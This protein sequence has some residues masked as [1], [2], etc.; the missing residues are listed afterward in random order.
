MKFQRAGLFL[1]LASTAIAVQGA[2]LDFNLAS[3]AVAVDY[4]AS[5]T[6]TGLEGDLSYLHHS[7]RAD[8]AAAGVDL[9]GNASPVGSP[10]IFGVGAKA[11]FISPKSTPVTPNDNGLAVGVG[12]HFR[13]TWPTYNRFAIGGEL[14]YAPSIVS[15][16]NADRYLQF[17]AR[18]AYQILRNADAYIGYRH[19]SAAFNG[20]ANVTL[21]SSFVVGLSLTF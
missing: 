7:D 8:I 17:G 12:A 19:I 16:Q 15:F 9:V 20:G 11:F 2:N 10:L 5:L 21:D 4:T 3:N 6:E 13:Y 14:Y 1:V 18:A